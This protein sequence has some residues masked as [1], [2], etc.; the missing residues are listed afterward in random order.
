[1]T[2]DILLYWFHYLSIYAA[3][4]GAVAVHLLLRKETRRSELGRAWV[5]QW[6]ATIGLLLAFSTG[7]LQ[8][9]FGVHEA[10]FYSK[11]GIFHLKVTLV[12]VALGLAWP[13]LAFL[14][15][16]KAGDPTEMVTVPKAPVMAL[17]LQLLLVVAVIPLLAL[18]MARGVGYFG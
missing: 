14:R 1:M 7:L 5:L 18:L 11:N 8:W 16:A 6:M 2:G 4:S 12:L 3:I 10:A 15:K 9:F 13:P 17:R